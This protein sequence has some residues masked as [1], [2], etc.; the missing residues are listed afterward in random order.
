MNEVNA[1]IEDFLVAFGQLSS[2][3]QILPNQVLNT[4]WFIQTAGH[5]SL[6]Y[7]IW[8]VKVSRVAQFLA[9]IG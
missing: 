7:G 6:L 3:T 4:L 8:A 2:D 1:L 9:G 5:E